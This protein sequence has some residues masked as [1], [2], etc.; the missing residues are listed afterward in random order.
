MA[1]NQPSV[2][3]CCCIETNILARSLPSLSPLN[4]ISIFGGAAASSSFL[5]TAAAAT[6]L[7]SNSADSHSRFGASCVQ[8]PTAQTT[9][10]PNTPAQPCARTS[11]LYLVRRRQR[12]SC[13]LE[14]KSGAL[15][16]FPAPSRGFV[17]NSQQLPAS[18]LASKSGRQAGGRVEVGNLGLGRRAHLNSSKH[19][20]TRSLGRLLP[21]L[22]FRLL[23]RGPRKCPSLFV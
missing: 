6:I 22:A 3:F 4:N 21:L 23:S 18:Q 10:I 5:H 14:G 7:P 2:H 9:P 17:S 15:S 20:L 16:T 19:P 1:T 8:T 13:T 11:D 12:L